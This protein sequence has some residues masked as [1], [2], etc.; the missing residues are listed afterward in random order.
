MIPEEKQAIQTILNTF[1]GAQVLS[2]QAI[3]DEVATWGQ[4]KREAY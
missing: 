4:A 1:P 3:A 2:P